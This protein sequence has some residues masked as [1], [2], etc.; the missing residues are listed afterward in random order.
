[1]ASS[2][3]TTV[4]DGI[5]LS[6]VTN[7]SRERKAVARKIIEEP[8]TGFGLKPILV[9]LQ[10]P[11]TDLNKLP[12]I[13][14]NLEAAAHK[15]D[16]LKTLHRLMY[17]KF[18]KPGALLGNILRFSGMP[19]R[20]PAQFPRGYEESFDSLLF[21]VN[22]LKVRYQPNQFMHRSNRILCSCTDGNAAKCVRRCWLAKRP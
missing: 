6:N 4:P 17:G 3:S 18:A 8:M 16:T 14:R 2:H 22:D 19:F 10:G 7:G 1:M 12:H 20:D 13:S 9:V 5:D 21:R 11:G 15:T